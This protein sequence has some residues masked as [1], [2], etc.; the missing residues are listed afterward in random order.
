MAELI[1]VYAIV[2]SLSLVVSLFT[3]KLKNKLKLWRLKKRRVVNW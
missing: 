1:I 3:N 2:L